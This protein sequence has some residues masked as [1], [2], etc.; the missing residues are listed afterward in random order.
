MADETALLEIA[1][2]LRETADILDEIA[3]RGE[4]PWIDRVADMPINRVPDHPDFVRN[5]GRHAFW[6]E[7]DLEDVLGLTIHHT[8]SHSPLGTAKYCTFTKGYPSV[9]YHWWVSA[10]DGCPV[11]MLAKPTWALWHDHTGANSKTLSIGMAGSLHL[12]R[13]ADEQIEAAAKLCA[14]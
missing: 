8:L 2:G 7:R 1:R 5:Y 3:G 14:T 4:A 11:W 10:G 13:P 9:Q 12:H 6:P